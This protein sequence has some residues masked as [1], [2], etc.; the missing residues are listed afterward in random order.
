MQPKEKIIDH[1]IP[2]RPWEV[3]GTNVFHFSNNNYL[4]IV[5]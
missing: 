2:L 5:D 3:L 4:C 1:D